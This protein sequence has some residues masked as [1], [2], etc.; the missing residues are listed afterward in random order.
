MWIQGRG[1]WISEEVN[2]GTSQNHT[3]FY[4]YTLIYSW[5]APLPLWLLIRKAV[6]MNAIAVIPTSTVMRRAE[7]WRGCS[8]RSHWKVMI[9]FHW[10]TS[11]Q[12]KQMCPFLELEEMQTRINDFYRKEKRERAIMYWS[13]AKW[14]HKEGWLPKNW[15]F[16]IAVLEKTLES[17]LDC[18]EIKPV[19]PEGNQPWMFIG[20]IDAEA[21]GLILWP[22]DAKSRLTGKDPDVGKDW[23]QEEK[24]L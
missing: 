8:L 22:P 16:W 7:K 5:W 1:F 19:N 2:T 3:A 10:V 21:K 18:K 23:G 15:C 24:G 14:L 12:W 4:Q 13:S 17:P 11:F 9:W 6:E 20:R